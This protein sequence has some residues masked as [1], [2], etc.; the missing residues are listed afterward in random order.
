MTQLDCHSESICWRHDLDNYNYTTHSLTFAAQATAAILFAVALYFC[1]DTESPDVPDL[2]STASGVNRPSAVLAN[3]RRAP[4][5]T[6]DVTHPPTG[7][8]ASDVIGDVT[9]RQRHGSVYETRL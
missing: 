4:A 6:A 3:Q 9:T 7:D 8:V 5:T 1:P 2:H